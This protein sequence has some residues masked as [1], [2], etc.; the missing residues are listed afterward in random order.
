M[1]LTGLLSAGGCDALD[2]DEPDP[3]PVDPTGRV[4]DSALVLDRGDE[5]GTSVSVDGTTMAVGA[6][7]TDCVVEVCSGDGDDPN[8]I[9]NAG[10]VYVFERVGASFQLQTK[11]TAPT[12]GRGDRFGGS[13][14]LSGDTLIIGAPGDSAAGDSAGAVYV[15]ARDGSEWTPVP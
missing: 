15:F 4:I 11:L 14:S 12:P 3:P 2:V 10:A 9:D 1:L 6:P 13:V 8:R 5:L 7:G